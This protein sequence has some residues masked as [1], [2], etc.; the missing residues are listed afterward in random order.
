MDKIKNALFRIK[1]G[2]GSIFYPYLDYGVES[3]RQFATRETLRIGEAGVRID[4]GAAGAETLELKFLFSGDD[5]QDQKRA[6][7]TAAGTASAWEIIHPYL[8]AFLCQ[9]VSGLK[10]SETPTVA[11]GEV[12]VK[13]VRDVKAKP[14]ISAKAAAKPAL[15]NIKQQAVAIATPLPVSAAAAAMRDTKSAYDFI[16]SNIAEVQ[17][18]KDTA[19]NATAK[20]AEAIAM[21][22]VFMQSAAD[23]LAFP[24]ELQAE[25][26]RAIA[27]TQRAW[28]VLLDAAR[29]FP[30]YF[31][32]AS[33]IM[34]AAAAN[35]AVNIN[36]ASQQQALD[37]RT[38]LRRIQ[39]ER[40]A[41]IDELG[42]FDAALDFE[43]TALMA[44]V[45]GQIVDIAAQA[46]KR[47]I[48]TADRQ[49]AP[50][51][52]AAAL[53][54]DMDIDEAQERLIQDNQLAGK[55]LIVIEAGRELVYFK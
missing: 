13:K 51:V 11:R 54:P 44:L 41:L 39:D 45:Q 52:F 6:F 7:I 5:A 33:A 26:T 3:G 24:A 1:L 38:F 49:A 25:I 46:D 30:N 23:L 35:M 12:S 18:L 14:E 17:Q 29:S 36:Y 21:P 42:V 34:Q 19:R 55:E 40:A 10:F 32:S 27:G 48:F 22:G 53:Y 37:M 9:P 15:D 50:L 31:F 28:A 8:G 20:A 16:P 2:N 43:F 47:K 4:R